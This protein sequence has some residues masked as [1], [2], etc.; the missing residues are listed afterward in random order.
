MLARDVCSANGGFL[1][2]LWASV[3]GG[4]YSHFDIRR[5]AKVFWGEDYKISE[6]VINAHMSLA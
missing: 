5:F 6:R 1:E 2:N 3:R 4:K